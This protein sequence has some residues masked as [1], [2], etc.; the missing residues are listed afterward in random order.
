MICHIYQFSVRERIPE[1]LTFAARCIGKSKTT[2]QAIISNYK[3]KGASSF[4]DNTEEMRG[5]FS[6][7]APSTHTR[8]CQGPAQEESLRVRQLDFVEL[9]RDNFDPSLLYHWRLATNPG[10]LVF[11]LIVHRCTLFPCKKYTVKSSS[12]CPIFDILDFSAI[13]AYRLLP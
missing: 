9:S 7:Y 10:S 12:F 6:R 2:V 4:S 13:L 3:A 5:R 1:P 8:V 11:V